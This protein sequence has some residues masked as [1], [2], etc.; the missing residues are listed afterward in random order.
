[1]N[2]KA[3]Q[4]TKKT[5]KVTFFSRSKNR[6]WTKGEKS[7]NYLKL[8]TL[9]EDC[10]KDALLIQ[11]EPMGPTCHMGNDTCWGELNNSHFGF[12]SELENIISS[13]KSSKLENSYISSLFI[14][15]INKIAQKVGEETVET[16]IE[17][18]DG[19]SE[20]FLN[21]TADLL[22]HLLILLQAKGFKLDD[23]ERILINRK[24]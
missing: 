17:A 21:E 8:I 13:R 2:K 11:V 20:L 23:V 9:K 3:L 18:K 15:G 1:M 19:N 7:G 24:K 16:I 5:K 14:K 4:I 10:D 22:F 6:L 12:F